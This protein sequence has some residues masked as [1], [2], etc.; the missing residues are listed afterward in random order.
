MVLTVDV[1]DEFNLH[2]HAARNALKAVD[3]AKQRAQAFDHAAA[4][5]L[6]ATAPSTSASQ[7]AQPVTGIDSKKLFF[8]RSTRMI[9]KTVL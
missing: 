3:A 7:D 6:A 2:A 8:S 4:E 9:S 1:D 5:K